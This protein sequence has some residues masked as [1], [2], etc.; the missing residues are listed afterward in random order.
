M[1]QTLSFA[2]EVPTHL[3]NPHATF[4]ASE[5]CQQKHALGEPA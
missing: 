1:E 2:V 3:R 4:A 5:G